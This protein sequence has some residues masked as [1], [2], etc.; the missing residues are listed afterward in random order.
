MRQS[1][2]S[3]GQRAAR[4]A[5]ADAQV[6]PFSSQRAQTDFDIA[7]TFAVSQL[8]KG[9][10]QKLVPAGKIRDLAIAVIALDAAAKLA[11]GN[12]IHQLRENGSSRIHGRNPPR[13]REKHAWQANASSNR[14]HPFSPL[15]PSPQK[16][17]A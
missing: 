3:C 9:H 10:A 2:V 7:Q 16:V 6:I 14:F 11:R 17:Y 1:R 13:I 8:R 4:D 12:K 5:A 15:K